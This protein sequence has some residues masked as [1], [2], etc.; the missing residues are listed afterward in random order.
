MTTIAGRRLL[1]D[2]GFRLLEA[3]GIRLLEDFDSDAAFP[4]VEFPLMMTVAAD[5][6]LHVAQ[7]EGMKLRVNPLA[8]LTLTI[9]D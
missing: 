6:E 3:G 7:V 1:E 4:S 5:L 2:G 9:G 8:E